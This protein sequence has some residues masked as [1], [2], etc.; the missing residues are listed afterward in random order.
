MEN[1]CERCPKC[2]G[3]RSY[4][5]QGLIRKKCDMCR[6]VGW[7]D[8]DIVSIKTR[9]VRED[10]KEKIDAVYEEREKNKDASDATVLVIKKRGRPK[11]EG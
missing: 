10:E 7:V 5:G 4:L 8:K 6:E 2:L 1:N 11:R 9:K 3:K